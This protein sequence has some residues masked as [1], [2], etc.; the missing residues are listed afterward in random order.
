MLVVRALTVIEDRVQRGQVLRVRVQ[1]HVDVLGL[2]RDDA[3]VVSGGSDFGRW[4]IGDRRERQQVRLIGRR[5][6]RPQARN[7]HHFAGARRE[8]KDQVLSLLARLQFATFGLVPRH[9]LVE[10]IG[11]HD[12][13]RVAELALPEAGAGRT[14]A[15]FK[16]VQRNRLWIGA[17]FLLFVCWWAVS[18]PPK[19][20]LA[21]P[22]VIAFP[23]Y[24]AAKERDF[25]TSVIP[26]EASRSV[27]IYLLALLPPVAFGA[28]QM[29]AA[30]IADG[31]GFSYVLS[32]VDGVDIRKDAPPEKRLRFLGY[33]GDHLFFLEPSEHELAIAKFK[34]ETALVVVP[35]ERKGFTWAEMFAESPKDGLPTQ[36]ASHSPAS[37]ASTGS[38]PK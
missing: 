25:L 31:V 4:L 21:L 33:V 29:R 18:G 9:I 12:P 11:Q 34:G 20:W 37:P 23:F 22:P 19:K 14:T 13:V 36:G 7:Q 32:T 24:M 1:P 15:S 2:D 26:G 28:G 6:A 17:L 30:D 35:Y 38:A 5:P 10:G 16:F 8:L 3:A 27:V